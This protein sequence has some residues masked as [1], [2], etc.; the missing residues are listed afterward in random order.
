MISGQKSDVLEARN[1]ARREE[2]RLTDCLSLTSLEACQVI[3]VRNTARGCRKNPPLDKA[4]NGYRS[5]SIIKLLF[6]VSEPIK[7]RVLDV[8]NPALVDH[9][10]TTPQEWR[11]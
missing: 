3:L 9:G 1:D 6:T 10:V 7:V 4:E 5:A 11:S 2:R 8:K